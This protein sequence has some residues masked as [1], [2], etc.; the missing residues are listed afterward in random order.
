MLPG[1]GAEAEIAAL[2]AM[3]TATGF[4]GEHVMARAATTP[5]DPALPWL[6]HV[7]VKSTRGGC[8]DGDAKELSRKAFRLLHQRYPKSEW[9]AKT[10]YH[11]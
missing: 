6:L 1:A 11:Y 7:V 8:L 10:P 3:K 9:A 4:V 5:K 2:G